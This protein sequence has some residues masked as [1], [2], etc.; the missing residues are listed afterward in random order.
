M[1]YFEAARGFRFGGVNEPAP[2][3]LCGADIAAI[4]LTQS[5][6][7]FGPDHLWSYTLGEKGTFADR[8]LLVNVDAFFINWQYVQTVHNLSCGYY[9]TENKGNVHSR[10]LELETKLRAT[11]A[12]TL[13]LSGSYTNATANGQIPN[14]VAQD[15]D[16]TPFFPKTIV[17]VNGEYA[18]RLQQSARLILAADYTYRSNAFTAFNAADPT[19]AE[20]PSST[21]VNGS[22]TYQRDRWSVGIY[23]TNLTNNHLVSSVVKNQY[24][25]YQPGDTQYWGRPR[26]LG[27]HFHIDFD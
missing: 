2:P 24:A 7:A 27:V 12:L 16:R 17:T 15:G 6:I 4:G 5:P 26:T 14:L 11:E 21:L 8:R 23:G 20:I 10:G 1:T 13:G 9:F 25:P 22:L 18:F 3:S 19:Y